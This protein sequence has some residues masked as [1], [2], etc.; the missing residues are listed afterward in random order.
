[1]S[2]SND[3]NVLRLFEPRSVLSANK[4]G[5][6]HLDAVSSSEFFF[7]S[8]SIARFA[9]TKNTRPASRHHHVIEAFHLLKFSLQFLQL[10]YAFERGRF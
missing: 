8:F 10:R 2:Q 4:F 9:Q 5:K 7:E 3:S 1:M 6:E